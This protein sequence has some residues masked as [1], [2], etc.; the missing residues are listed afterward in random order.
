MKPFQDV[1]DIGSALEQLSVKGG[2]FLTVSQGSQLNTM[3]IG[4]GAIGYFW[5]KP[6]FIAAVRYSRYTHSF[7][8][9]N[10]DFTVSIPTNSESKKALAYCGTKSGKDV[11]KFKEMQLVALPGKAQST[12]V[13]QGDFLQI[14]CVSRW[15]SEVSEQDLPDDIKQRFY[16]SELPLERHVLYFGEIVSTYQ[17]KS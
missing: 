15:S 10:P 16:A 11:D 4:W 2:A 1:V 8:E 12:P 6:F 13:I 14:E 7:L 3:T 17:T 5:N 9:K